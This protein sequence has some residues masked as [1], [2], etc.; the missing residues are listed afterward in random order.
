MIQAVELPVL[1][2]TQPKE[3]ADAT[4]NRQRIL[5]AAT[6]LFA[7]R[8]VSCTSMDAIAAEAGVGKGTVFRRFGDRA[9]LALAVLDASEVELQES[10]IRGE[11]P[12]G[13]GAPPAARLVAFG[14]AMYTRLAEHLDILLEAELSGADALRSAPHGVHRMHV[15]HL[16]QHARP[17]ADAD[18]LADVLLAPLSARVVHDQHVVRGMSLAQLRTGYAEL[19]ARLLPA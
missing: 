10:L 3:R 12:L 14:E 11:P 13:P 1:P 18:Y 19:V 7:D 15:R 2:T 8:G 5:D 16:V 4:A 9:S 6:R 17:D